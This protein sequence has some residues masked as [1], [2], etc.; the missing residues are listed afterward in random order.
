MG[1]IRELPQYSIGVDVKNRFA[2]RYE[3][4]KARRGVVE[5]LKTVVKSA[6]NVYIATDQDREG[7]A[8]AWHLT[9]VTRAK[10]ERVRRICFHEITKEALEEALKEPR[11]IDMRIVNAQQ[12]RRIL[13]RLV[14]YRISSLLGKKVRRRLSAGRVQSVAL[15]LIVERERETK[16]FCQQEY[17]TIAAELKGKDG[18]ISEVNLIHEG[19]KKYERTKILHLFGEDYKI[20]VTSIEDEGQTARIISRLKDAQYQ[21]AKVKRSQRKRSPSPPFMTSTLQQ[22]A[23]QKLGLS[24]EDTMKVAQQLYEGIQLGEEG[25]VGL[26]TYMRTDSLNVASSACQEAMHFVVGQFGGEYQPSQPRIYRTKAKLAQE[27]H[28][29]IRPTSVFR[30]PEKIGK[31]LS[32]LQLK[33]YDLVWRRFLASQMAD[34]LFDTISADITAGDYLFRASGQSIKFD[35][36]MKIYAEPRDQS[37]KGETSPKGGEDV[38]LPHL[39]EGEIL[40]LE[41]FFPKQHFT[42]PPPRYNMASLVRTLE[43]HGI[44][45]PSTYAPIISTILRRGYVVLRDKRF[46]PE[47]IGVVVTDLL[48]K[49]FPDIVDLGF[50]AQMEKNLDEVAVG[51]REWVSILEEFYQPFSETLTLAAAKMRIIK[52]PPEPTDQVCELCGHSM[53]IR[54]GRYGRF[55]ACSYFPKCRN[56]RSLPRELLV[57]RDS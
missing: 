54:E 21:V 22:E 15:R 29:A 34:A 20:R 40:T 39:V 30:T 35:G 28:E 52:P 19:N 32:S 57:K 31:F 26:I 18:V 9:V 4:L 11:Q 6:D 49:H 27:A 46:H 5:D 38:E 53:V 36:F 37:A 1:H 56:T 44:G 55:L 51:R 12:A 41:R 33:L 7:E 2:P 8:I 25:S 13:D 17:W 24:A 48:I 47:K 43:R 14:G 10:P 16:S 3:I 23:S 42:Q 50:T 45:R